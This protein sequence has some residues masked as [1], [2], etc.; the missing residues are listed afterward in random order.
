MKKLYLILLLSFL[1]FHFTYL[2]N[3][4]HIWSTQTGT[5]GQIWALAVNPVNQQTMYAGSNTTG[6]WKS[7]NGGSNWSLINNGLTNLTVQTIA[8]SAS[9]PS[10]LYCG[11]SQTGGGGVFKTTNA[12]VSWSLVNSGIL[13]TSI[14]IQSIVV[15]P[16]SPDIA[17]IGV[18]DGLV[19]STVGLYRTTNG[20]TNWLPANTGFGEIKNVLSLAMNP[21]NSNVIYAGT[22]HDVIGMLLPARIYKSVNAG[23]SWTDM[24]N[25]LPFAPGDIK[26]VRCLSISTLDTQ[27]VLAGLFNNTDSL[28]GG[29]FMS[30]NGGGQWNRRNTGVPG[31]IG[32]FPR[33]CLIRPG[34]ATEFYVGL[35]NATNTNIGIY[36]TTNAGFTWSSFNNGTML[37]TY[38]VRALAFRTTTDSTIFAGSAHPSLATGQGV[39]EYSTVITEIENNN[40]IP[41][42]FSLKQNY[43]N[44]FNPST[45]ISFSIPKSGFVKLEVFDI[46]GKLIKTLINNNLSAGEHDIAFDASALSSGIYLYRLSTGSFTQT[47]TM[48]LMK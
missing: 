48:V 20:G 10:I 32:T 33:A 39:F 21:S 45:N 37:N 47:R 14:S 3:G 36:K 41:D 27:V 30:S 40:G 26:P 12:G 5:S 6:M 8:I 4:P 43:P 16:S 38:T 1:F 42:K 2:S 44:P 13:E 17:Y 7:T 35:G 23:A 9:N 22:S 19:N 11:T 25:G 18:F 29:M 34:S 15:N 28:S 24:S 46:T 31:A